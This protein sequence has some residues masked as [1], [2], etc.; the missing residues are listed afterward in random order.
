[1]GDSR[2]DTWSTYNMSIGRDELACASLGDFTIFAGGSAPQVN[3]SET[4]EVD[5]WNH[6]TGAW[7]KAKLSQKRKKPQAVS[8]GGKIVI[9]GGEIAKPPPEAE[10]GGYSDVVD[11]FDPETGSFS[12]THMPFPPRQYFGSVS[13]GDRA[14][15]AGGFYNDLR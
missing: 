9:A 14:I 5:I 12:I 8:A 4:D 6:R 3:Q 7:T 15:F 2:A 13:A 10:V 11:V 1:M